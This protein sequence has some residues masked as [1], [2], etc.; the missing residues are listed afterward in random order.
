[1]DITIQ[2]AEVVTLTDPIVIEA[3]RDLFVQKKIVAKIKG[4]SR[5]II[6]WDGEEQYTAA[7]N[8]TNDT[9]TVQASAVLQ[10]SSI[11]WA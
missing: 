5:P 6:L 7:G 4:L 2:Q 9:A 10:L 11:P 8:W 3:V 1:M